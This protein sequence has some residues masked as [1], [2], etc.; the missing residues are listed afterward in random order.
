MLG[1]LKLM[2]LCSDFEDNGGPHEFVEVGVPLLTMAQQEHLFGLAVCIS[3]RS[4]HNDSKKSFEFSFWI[5][6]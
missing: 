2:A 5:W 6:F 3:T 4:C 1:V